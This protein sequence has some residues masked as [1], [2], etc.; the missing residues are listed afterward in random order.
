MGAA[1]V[2][3]VADSRA[4]GAGVIPLLVTSRMSSHRLPGKALRIVAGKPLL[5]WVVEAARASAG[6]SQVVVATSDSAS[7]EP[8]RSW[9]RESGVDWAVGP[10]E[11][12]LTRL[13]RTATALSSEAVVRISGDSPL[14]DPALI[15]HAIRLFGA[16]ECDLVTNVHPRTFPQGQ[17]VEVISTALLQELSRRSTDPRQREHVTLGAYQGAVTARIL[18]FTAQELAPEFV[19]ALSREGISPSGIKLSLDTA[20]DAV[21]VEGV[22]RALHPTPPSRAGWVACTRAGVA[23]L[24]GSE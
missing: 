7:D 5:E 1:Q 9:C 24:S 19:A 3:G 14:V 20:Q 8:I 21:T 11:D 22:V 13:A 18:N 15:D 16:A 17:S 23:E 6:T 12:M 10:L 2:H 4:E